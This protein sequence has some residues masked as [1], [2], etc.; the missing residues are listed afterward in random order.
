MNTH[1]SDSRDRDQNLETMRP[2]YDT[3]CQP[4][5][6][7]VRNAGR[8]NVDAQPVYPPNHP[9]PAAADAVKREATSPMSAGRASCST[10]PDMGIFSSDEQ[11]WPTSSSA[12]KGGHPM[13]GYAGPAVHPWLP[14]G[15]AAVPFHGNGLPLTVP[16]PATM[17]GDA[18]YQAAPREFSAIRNFVEFLYMSKL[19]A[20]KAH[21]YNWQQRKE[22]YPLF[23][24]GAYPL[25]TKNAIVDAAEDAAPLPTNFGQEV[26][27]LKL[28][29][30]GM[31]HRLPKKDNASKKHSSVRYRSQK[32]FV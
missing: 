27:K 28:S 23:F 17:P 19:E 16:P 29:P 15:A 1:F 26:P 32:F 14:L 4:L 3:A 21:E 10:S 5:D 8:V 9:A 7:V 12:A 6:L 22:A 18:E 25:P 24:N 2:D 11:N 31:F 30:T 20:W 13:V